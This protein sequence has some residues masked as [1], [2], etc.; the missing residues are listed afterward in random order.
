MENLKRNGDC[1]KD[2]LLDCTDHSLDC[3]I[4][5]A[6]SYGDYR[7]PHPIH[8]P[9]QCCDLTFIVA[10]KYPNIHW[11]LCLWIGADTC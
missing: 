1:R 9:E 10:R 8:V 7:Y 3:V 2:G 11:I 4:V 6:G 5:L